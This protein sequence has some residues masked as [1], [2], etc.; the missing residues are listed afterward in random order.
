MR[1]QP[2]QR[3][4]HAPPA[5]VEHGMTGGPVIYVQSQHWLDA[6]GRLH[7]LAQIA[8]AVGAGAGVPFA[9]IAGVGMVSSVAGA[10]ATFAL[11]VMTQ[12]SQFI[13]T[14][15]AGVGILIIVV[16]GLVAIS[17]A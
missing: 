9:L 16:L 5:T 10:V 1:K 13:L 12:V 8:L 4:D 17:K 2:L 7:P 6:V 3:I 15:G 14:V 11:A